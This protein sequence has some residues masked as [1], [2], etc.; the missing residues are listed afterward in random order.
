MISFSYTIHS[1]LIGCPSQN[2]EA[3]IPNHVRS[4]GSNV[5]RE[6]AA[7]KITFSSNSQ[8]IAVSFFWFSSEKI[9]T[10]YL[11]ISLK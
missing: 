6:S 9:K 4:I 10:L 11:P 3:E 2:T 7:T 8:L 5:F 1:N